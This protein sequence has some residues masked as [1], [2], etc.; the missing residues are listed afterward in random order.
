[1]PS[2]AMNAAAA[3]SSVV[4]PMP[5]SLTERQRRVIAHMVAAVH[6]AE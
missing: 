5:R 3:S 6:K 4:V 1:M 2:P